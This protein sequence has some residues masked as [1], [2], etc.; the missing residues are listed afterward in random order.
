L[1]KK[2]SRGHSVFIIEFE[3]GHFQE[4]TCNVFKKL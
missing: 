2:C 3:A 4:I 1:N